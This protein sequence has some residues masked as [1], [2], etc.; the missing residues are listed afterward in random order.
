MNKDSIKKLDPIQNSN[1]YE[2]SKIL[3]EKKNSK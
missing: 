1:L 2:E 3:K